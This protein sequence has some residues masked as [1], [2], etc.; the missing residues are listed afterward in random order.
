MMDGINK[1]NTTFL[2]EYSVVNNCYLRGY[3]VNYI[4]EDGDFDRIGFES[5]ALDDI[6][7]YQ[8]E[9][10]D[11]IRSGINLDL[12]PKVINEISFNMNEYEYT[13]KYQIGHNHE[14]G[15][16]EDFDR[17]GEVILPLKTN[18]IQECFDLSNV[19]YRFSAF[20]TLHIDYPFKRITLYKKGTR[21]G[22][23]YCPYVNEKVIER[24]DLSFCRFNVNK[25]VPKMLNNIALDVGDEIKNNI[26]LGYLSDCNSV[27]KPI[28]FMEQIVAFEYLY[29]KI[30][31]KNAQSK[32]FYLYDELIEMFSEYNEIVWQNFK[33][34][35]ICENIKEMR[36]IT[37]GYVYYYAFKKGS[38]KIYIVYILDKLLKCMS[39]QVMGFAK[40]D[41]LNLVLRKNVEWVESD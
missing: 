40:E 11:K 22:F 24:Y 26:P 9:Y 39:L 3:V 1:R 16:L 31:H 32:T 15:L 4:I 38:Y 10:L 25:Y 6:F 35:E 17:N 5:N 36:R 23:L 12:E 2:V 19:L 37:H 28:R 27:F 30:N 7:R 33:V 20:L 13:L 41:I 14:F 8:Y 18:E 29:D 21:F 34:E